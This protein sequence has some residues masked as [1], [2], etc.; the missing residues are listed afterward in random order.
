MKV[1]AIGI[2]PSVHTALDVAGYELGLGALGGWLGLSL[3]VFSA[4]IL[5]HRLFTGRRLQ[6]MSRDRLARTEGEQPVA[7]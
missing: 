7:A 6:R 5:G 4:G 1:L 3:E 2:A